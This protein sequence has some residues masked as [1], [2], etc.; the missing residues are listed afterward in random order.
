MGK[1]LIH[2][3]ER[4]IKNLTPLLIF[5]FGNICIKKTGVRENITA[6]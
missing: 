4:S 3:K 6:R 1:Y 5:P 2:Y